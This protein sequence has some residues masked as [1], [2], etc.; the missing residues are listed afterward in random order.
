MI[1]GHESISEGDVMQVGFPQVLV[2]LRRRGNLGIM[3]DLSDAELG[4]FD[5]HRQGSFP[6][7]L[8]LSSS[9]SK[10]NCALEI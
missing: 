4:V 10:D 3:V 6:P 9:S 7:H 1:A 2:P 5:L 8:T